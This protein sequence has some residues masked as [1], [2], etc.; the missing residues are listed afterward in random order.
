MDRAR[1]DA[2]RDPRNACPPPS[3]LRSPASAPPVLTGVWSIH[4]NDCQSLE[5]SGDLIPRP[6]PHDQ[7]RQSYASLPAGASL[8][9]VGASC[10]ASQVSAS[11]AAAEEAVFGQP[12]CGHMGPNVRRLSALEAQPGLARVPNMCGLPSARFIAAARAFSAGDRRHLLGNTVKP[13]KADTSKV[14]T[15]E[16]AGPLPYKP[17]TVLPR[18]RP[19]PS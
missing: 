14:P 8:R 2:R 16:P 5:R 15:W 12:D 18:T 17:S 9:C 19:A 4:T 7:P 1:C 10:A 6:L 3:A 13:L 11:V